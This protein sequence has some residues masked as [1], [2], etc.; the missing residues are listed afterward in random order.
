MNSAFTRDR[1]IENQKAV[2]KPETLKPGTILEAKITNKAFINKENNPKERI[3]IGKVIILTKGLINIFITP[4]TT[5]K[6][7]APVNVTVAPGN[8]YAEIII[9]MADTSKCDNS[10]IYLYYTIPI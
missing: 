4:K 1:I 3:V 9:A 8:K 7:K 2:Q 6:T 10:F 5:A